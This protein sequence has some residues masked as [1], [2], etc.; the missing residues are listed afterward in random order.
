MPSQDSLPQ[1]PLAYTRRERDGPSSA[2]VAPIPL[3]SPRPSRLVRYLA[4]A[5]LALSLLLVA[6]LVGARLWL[7]DTLTAALPPLDGTVAVAG[8]T[9][10]VTVRRDPRGIPTLQASS[11]DDLIVAQGYVTAEDRL[12][13]MDAIRRHAAGELA[14]ILGSGLLEHDRM[15]RTLQL[16]ASADRAI[17][18]ML[19]DQLHW[20]ELYAR[21]VNAAATAMH[22]HLPIEF[23]LLRYTPRPWTPRD[24]MLVS[25]A[26]FEDLTNRFPEKLDREALTARLA[27]SAPPELRAQLLSDL[28]PVGSW[29]DH[30]PTQPL[31]DLTAPVDEIPDVPLDDSQVK[32][33]RPAALPRAEVADLL[34]LTQSLFPS[35]CP[36][37]QPGSNNWVVSGAHTASGQS[38]LSNDMHL[39]LA[40]PGIWYAASLEAPSGTGSEPFHVAGVTLPGTPF[41]IVGHNVHVAWGFTNLGADVQDLYVEHLRGSGANSEFQTPAGTWRPVLHAREVIHVRGAP[42]QILDVAATEHGSAVTPIISSLVPSEPRPVSLRWAIYDR[43]VLGSPFFPINSATGAASLVEAFRAFGGPSQNLVYADDQGHIGYHATGRIPIRGPADH[44]SSLLSVPIDATAPDAS[45]HEW[46]GS[47][48]YDQLPQVSDPPGGILATANARITPDGYPFPITDNWGDPYRNERIWKLLAGR[49]HLTPA[50]MLAMQGDIYSDLDR[51]VAHRLAYA[52]DHATPAKNPKRLRQAADL[53]RTWNGRVSSDS[54]AAAIVDAARAALWPLLLTPKLDPLPPTPVKSSKPVPQPWQLYLWSERAFA[55]EQLILHTPARWLPPAYA[56]WDDLLAAAVDRGLADSHAPS[57]LSRWRYGAAHPLTIEH[58]IFS[59]SA[60]LRRL[61]GFPT[62]IHSESQSGD[63]TT[64]K[65]TGRS[66]GPSERF[67]ADLADLDRSTLNL[68]LGQSGD[69]ASPWFLDQFPAWLHVST[70]PLP[71]SDAAV[72]SSTTHTLTLNPR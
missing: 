61:L 3:I 22:D 63:G 7:R 13:Q 57:N 33:R 68:V 19:P 23:R 58:P 65:Q 51:V 46:S 66:F 59:Q 36:G 14:E 72:T 11:L 41:V 1:D 48:P 26:M 43:G 28:F 39:S 38:L 21:G 67:T 9:S 4:L 53:L 18:D 55:E 70:F 40:V 12:F 32:L 52:I 60:P 34:A 6:A 45:A 47:I 49:E 5:G 2:E 69:P 56:T 20:L 44:P 62:G 29:R 64:V 16:R 54:P 71:F 17:A 37:C 50:D 42:D 30:P 31:P 25:L 35:S 8:L 10:P 27:P 24:S 15:Q